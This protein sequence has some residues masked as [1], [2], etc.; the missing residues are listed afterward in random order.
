MVAVAL[1]CVHIAWLCIVF[2]ALHFAHNVIRGLYVMFEQFLVQSAA[3]PIDWVEKFINEDLD[4][5]ALAVAHKL[6]RQRK[7]LSVQVMPVTAT[8]PLFV[9]VFVLIEGQ[10]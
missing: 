4:A 1:L 5:L 7:I 9:V 2:G 8:P 3:I 6:Y 10:T